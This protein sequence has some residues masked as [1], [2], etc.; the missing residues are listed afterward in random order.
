M[1]KIHKPTMR[2]K[3]L[4][5]VFNAII[6]AQHG[7][8]FFLMKIKLCSTSACIDGARGDEGNLINPED[9]LYVPQTFFSASKHLF[10]TNDQ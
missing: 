1:K 6:Q 9:E 8:I 7:E 10:L 5:K 2:Y 3:S 4:K